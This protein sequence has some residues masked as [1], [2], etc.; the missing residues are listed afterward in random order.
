MKK[1]LPFL[2][3]PVFLAAC[4]GA[5]A[6]QTS[7]KDSFMEGCIEQD[8]DKELCSCVYSELEDKYGKEHLE[9]VGQDESLAD[10]EMV[11][12]IATSTMTCMGIR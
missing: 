9:K 4:G 12:F 11:E 7:F 1:Y 3:L 2:L 10:E 6:P 5:S 8:S